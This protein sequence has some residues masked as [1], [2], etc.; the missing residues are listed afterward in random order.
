V[1]FSVDGE[2]SL[3]P[4]EVRSLLAAYAGDVA[5]TADRLDGTTWIAEVW[6][7]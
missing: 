1:T 4:L 3:A 5:I 6:R 7:L 2:Q